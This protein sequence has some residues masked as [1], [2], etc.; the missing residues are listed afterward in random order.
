MAKRAQCAPPPKKIIFWG[1][2]KYE[3]RRGGGQKYALVLNKIY[4]PVKT[5]LLFRYLI[6]SLQVDQY[7]GFIKE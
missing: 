4:T 1:K 5:C 2:T 3:S 6:N 7:L